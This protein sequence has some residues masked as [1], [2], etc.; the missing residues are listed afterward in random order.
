MSW[1]LLA[2]AGYLVI[3][4]FVIRWWIKSN[5]IR[6]DLRDERELKRYRKYIKVMNKSIPSKENKP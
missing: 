5:S 4:G 2:I 3:L 1:L 6:I